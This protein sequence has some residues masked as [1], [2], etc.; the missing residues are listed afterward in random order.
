MSFFKELGGEGL[1][2]SNGCIWSSESISYFEK[3]LSFTKSKSRKISAKIGLS[4][5][6]FP[7]CKLNFHYF[8]PAQSI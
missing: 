1:Q 4:G 3:I 6:I 2:K 5:K 8:I 7:N